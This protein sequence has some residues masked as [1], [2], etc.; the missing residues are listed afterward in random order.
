M[1]KDAHGVAQEHLAA[2][3]VSRRDFL[4]Y[5]GSRR[6][7][8]RPVAKPYAPQI[9][10]AVESGAAAKLAPVVWL[11]HG[12]CTGCT[13]SMAQVGLPGRARPIVLDLLSINYRET[14]MAAAGDSGG[15]GAQEDRSRQNKGKYIII[16]EGSVMTGAGGNTLRIAGKTGPRAAQGGRPEGRGDHRGR[17]VRGRRRLGRRPART[18]PAAIGVERR[19]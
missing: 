7:D 3:G 1:A 15:R 11:D 10:A 8:A 18:P 9:A 12:L 17:L 6:G 19:S 2:R 5:C 4:K 14:V 16:V 13:E